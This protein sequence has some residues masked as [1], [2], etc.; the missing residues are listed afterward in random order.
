[1][2]LQILRHRKSP[3][4]LFAESYAFHMLGRTLPK[5]VSHLIENTLAKLHL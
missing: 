3:E 1:M 2:T 4:E 5:K